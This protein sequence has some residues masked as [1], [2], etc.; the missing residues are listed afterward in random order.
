MLIKY[1]MLLWFVMLLWLLWLF[2]YSSTHIIPIAI[3]LSWA[4][5][6]TTHTNVS[7]GRTGILLVLFNTVSPEPQT[8]CS[9]YK[10]LRECS[11]IYSVISS[12]CKHSQSAYHVLGTVVTVLR[13]SM[14]KRGQASET[15][16]ALWP[17]AIGVPLWISV[18]LPTDQ[19]TGCVSSPVSTTATISWG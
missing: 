14:L 15:A 7:S 2:H 3:L 17:M 19:G 8:V 13:R 5:I 11:W 16:C 1:L 18:P 4:P 10:A 6:H 12:F 9:S